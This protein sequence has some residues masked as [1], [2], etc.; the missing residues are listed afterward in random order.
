M[1]TL[2]TFGPKWMVMATLASFLSPIVGCSENDTVPNPP[3]EVSFQLLNTAGEPA[4]S[5]YEGEDIIF[6]YRL[7]NVGNVD[8]IWDSQNDGDIPLFP[9]F[10]VLNDRDRTLVGPV[11]DPALFGSFDV[12]LGRSLQPSEYI[13][14]RVTWLGN[15]KETEVNW[16]GIMYIGNSALSKGRYLVEFEHTLQIPKFDDLHISI[17]A[18]FEVL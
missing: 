1:K 17:Y 12:G 4:T 3:V 8:V 16:G 15:A 14:I 9:V 5:F 7:I 13:V 6:D 2:T 10:R 18:P 11:Y